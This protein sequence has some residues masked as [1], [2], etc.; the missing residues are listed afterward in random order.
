[1]R[2]LV[3][4]LS[5]NSTPCRAAGVAGLLAAGLLACSAPPLAPERQSPV[6]PFDLPRPAAG[7]LPSVAT[8]LAYDLHLTVDPREE[9]FDGEVRIHLTVEVPTRALPFHAHDLEIREMWVEAPGRPK[10]TGEVARGHGPGAEP[11]YGERMALLDA[12]ITP[13]PAVLYLRWTA[14]FDPRLAGLYRASDGERWYAFSQLQPTEARK[15]FPS[16]DEPGFKTPFRTTLT[17]PTGMGAFTNAPE[18]AREDLGEWTVHRFEETPPLPTYLLAFA[19]GELDVVE[20][21]DAS[22]PIRGLAAKGRGHLMSTSLEMHAEILETLEGW[23]GTPYP[24][25]KLDVVAALEF[26]A[27]AMENAGLVVYREELALVDPETTPVTRLQSIA[28]TVAHELAH[29]WFGNLVTLAWWD[30]LWLNEAFATWMAARGVDLWRPEYA[31]RLAMLGWRGWAF[32][33]DALAAARAIR[34]PVRTAA[35]A[36]DAFDGLTYVKGALVLQMIERWV[37]PAAF[38]AGVQAYL[39]AHAWQTATTA[40]L[41]RALEAAAPDR[42]VQDVVATFVDRPGV[43]QVTATCTAEAEGGAAVVHLAQRRYRALGSR[44]PD[45][46][47]DGGPWAI[48]VCIAWPEEDG[49]NGTCLR[50]DEAEATVPLAGHDTCPSWIHPNAGEHGYYRWAVAPKMLPILGEAVRTP[51]TGTEALG[52]DVADRSRAGLP[53]QAWSMVTA[54]S[55]GPDAYLRLVEGLAS[56]D[57]PR[58]LESLVHGVASL[59]RIFEDLAETDAF[60]DWVVRVLGP[61]G[62]RLDWPPESE[63]DPA[64]ARLR[65][66]VLGL[67]ARYGEVDWVV[68]GAGVQAEAYLGDLGPVPAETVSMALATAAR[69]GHLDHGRLVAFLEAAETPTARVN[70]LT[71]LG[72]LPAGDALG[73]ALAEIL[74]PRVR[75]QDVRTLLFTAM[76]RPEARAQAFAFFVEHFDAIAEKMPAL[77]ARGMARTAEIVG[78]FCDPESRDAARAFFEK[79]GIEGVEGPLALGLERADQCIALREKGAEALAAYLAAPGERLAPP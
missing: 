66:A 52:I 4:S 15:V 31:Q 53:D 43:P 32:D 3:P 57:D 37:G 1:M 61:V 73:T 36:E 40:D 8:P 10:I 27:G 16:L 30:D 64:L 2:T 47:P 68:E 79:T 38:R 23:F 63:T 14:P 51:W 74:G 62:R 70:A 60:R 33:R 54:G 24:Y 69:R 35:E 77:G 46:F 26:A 42:P 34:Q 12:V 29:M 45:A 6:D 50:L 49:V 58:L 19:V 44:A 5:S 48:P 55:V 76:A 75:A 9:T 39:E 56:S 13:G 7:R 78:R 18:L 41:V 20:G 71:A 59:A 67:L 28:N 11:E 21:P 72:N 22:V 17:V 65:P 25:A